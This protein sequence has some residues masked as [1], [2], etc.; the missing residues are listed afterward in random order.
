MPPTST[1]M[2]HA[3]KNT[4]ISH[5]LKIGLPSILPSSLSNRFPFAT[6]SITLPNAFLEAEWSSSSP[7]IGLMVFNTKYRSMP[8]DLKQK[9]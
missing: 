4:N 9:D 8:G 5:S 2:H 3:G 6:C 7:F 1:L